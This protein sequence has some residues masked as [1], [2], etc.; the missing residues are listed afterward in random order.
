MTIQTFDGVVVLA[1]IISSVLFA[2]SETDEKSVL[3]S[4]LDVMG[5]LA[6]SLVWPAVC[7]TVVVVVEVAFCCLRAGGLV[8]GPF[9][10]I[11]QFDGFTN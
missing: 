10:E 3:Y 8:L 1:L 2:S 4:L 9:T 11:F 7:A 6:A 5:S